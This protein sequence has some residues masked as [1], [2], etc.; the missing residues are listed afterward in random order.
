MEQ[1]IIKRVKAALDR[2]RPY[3]QADGG[4]ISFVDLID[5]K[6][7]HV[8]LEGACGSCPYS[9]MTLKS[10]VEK[11]IKEDAPEIEEVVAV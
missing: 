4:D 1:D 3:L 5:N 6:I 2:V 8:K 10:G 11:A 9:A 7:V